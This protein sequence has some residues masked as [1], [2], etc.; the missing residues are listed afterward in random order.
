MNI[1]VLFFSN[2]KPLIVDYAI[3]QKPISVYDLM[4]LQTK[5]QLTI[6]DFLTFK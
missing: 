6:F 3:I 4:N 5:L 2:K 1:F